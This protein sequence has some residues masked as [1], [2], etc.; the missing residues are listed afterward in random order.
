[1]AIS[2]ADSIEEILL[3][4]MFVPGIEMKHLNNN[5]KKNKTIATAAKVFSLATILVV[6]IVGIITTPSLTALGSRLGGG[7]GKEVRK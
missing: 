1:L 7:E 4:K 6:A 5:K 3:S 2:P